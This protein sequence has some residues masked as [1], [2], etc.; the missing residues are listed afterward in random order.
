MLNKCYNNLV[1]YYT[2]KQKQKRNEKILW[3]RNKGFT[4][5]AIAGIFHISQVR[6]SQIIKKEKERNG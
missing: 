6:I 4:Q 1:N 5:E 2:L 3:Y